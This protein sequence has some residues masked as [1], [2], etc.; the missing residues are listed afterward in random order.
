MVWGNVLSEFIEF[1]QP[2]AGTSLKAYYKFDETSGDIINLAGNVTGNS[3]L[4][5]AADL[6][7]SGVTYN[8][9]G[10]IGGAL[11]YDGVNDY[12]QAGTSLSQFNFLHNLSALYTIVIWY[13]LDAL[14]VS[15]DT[16]T[17]TG[18]DLSGGD[19]GVFLQRDSFTGGRRVRFGY[20]NSGTFDLFTTSNNFLPNDTD[21]F[22]LLV[23]RFD[24]SLGSNNGLIRVDNGTD[25]SFT[26][27]VTA[28]NSDAAS[29]LRAGAITGTHFYDGRLDEYSIWNRILTDAE[30][31]ILWNGG[32]G[33]SLY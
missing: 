18:D 12:T 9:T 15:Y 10:K 16:F 11:E 4:G 26:R 24:Y 19:T 32:A 13:K 23:V 29:A 8:Q 2:I 31:T 5:S 30:L 3:S 20:G 28:T 25:E 1:G 27:T 22:H 21:S 14:E 7:T 17:N 6:Q 33:R